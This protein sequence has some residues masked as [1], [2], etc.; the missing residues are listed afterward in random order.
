M[1]EDSSKNGG[2]GPGWRKL[3]ERPVYDN[4]WIR[5]T[6]FDVVAPTGA[7]GIYGLV[8][9]KNLAVGVVPIDDTGCTILI[10]QDRFT[11]GAYS[12]ELPEGGGRRDLAPEEAARRELS[13]EA[14]LGARNWAPLFSDVQ[15]SNSVTDELAYAFLAWDLFPDARWEKDATE[16]LSVRRVPF[17]AAVEM[18]VSGEIVDAFSLV[19]LLKADHLA[20]TKKLPADL[21]GLMLG[22]Q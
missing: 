1:S 22:G 13:E 8:H 10:G 3:A 9:F 16:A 21:A 2:S 15:M 20:R 17:P 11:S 18:A 12:W 6:E 7:E 19:M 5:V 14:G 4:R